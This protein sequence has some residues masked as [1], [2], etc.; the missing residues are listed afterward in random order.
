LAGEN[1][2]IAKMAEYVSSELLSWFRWKRVQLP[3]QNFDCVKQADHTAKN[4]TTHT[5]P[6]DTVFY[7]SDPYL[8]RIIY[9]NTDL[10]SYASG[11]INAGNIYEALK[12]LAHTID[13]ARACEEWQDRY[14][15]LGDLAYEVRGML[16]VYNHDS[17]YDKS[18][19]DVL[20]APIRRRGSSEPT[21]IK[22]EGVPIQDG[23]AIHIFEPQLISYLTTIMTD[24]NRLHAAGSFPEKQYEFFY[25]EL[26]LHKTTGAKFDRPA[27]AEMLA[28]PYLIIRHDS[29][30]KYNETT[31][32]LEER[33]PE[34][35][36]VYYN[37]PGASAEEFAYFLDLLSGYQILDGEHKIRVRIAHHSPASD[38]IS[39][40]KRAIVL[41]AQEWNF[42]QHKLQRLNS[43]EVELVE[44]YR[45]SF[46]KT[47][48]GWERK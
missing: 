20:T 10:K 8:N 28:G 46:S 21:P 35:F 12:S 44:I 22:L 18:F 48:I 11:S 47:V 6:V 27:T 41:Y 26:R 42:D 17:D 30:K 39:N 31:Q 2:A 16:F 4:K 15:L 14:H 37:R 25:P 5:H 29:I 45:Y 43:I 32:S 1:E 7:Y 24:A 33:H 13:C 23:Q 3:N 36:I 19:Y 34:G 9:L 38:P 40:F